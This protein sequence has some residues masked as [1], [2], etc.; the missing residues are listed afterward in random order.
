MMKPS[1]IECV[2]YVAT[3]YSFL[4]PLFGTMS[5]AEYAEKIASAYDTTNPAIACDVWYAKTHIKSI[6]HKPDITEWTINN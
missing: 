6:T 4:I 2:R 1:D 3:A 5:G